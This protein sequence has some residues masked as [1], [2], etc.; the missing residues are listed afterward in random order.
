V[1]LKALRFHYCFLW[2]AILALAEL[3][4]GMPRN[5][6]D[7]AA[8]IAMQALSLPAGLVAALAVG[9]ADLAFRIEPRFWA[10]RLGTAV[11]WAL[12]FAAGYTQWFVVAPWLVRKLRRARA[13]S[14]EEG[15]PES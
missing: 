2:L 12:F 14:P 9:L 1:W 15:A 5:S 8:A 4:L 11:G 10:T 7:T 13:A 3:R 6:W